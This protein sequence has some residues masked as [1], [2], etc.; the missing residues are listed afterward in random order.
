MPRVLFRVA[1]KVNES[2]WGFLIRVAENNGLD[3]PREILQTL[4]GSEDASA[5]WEDVAA[6]AEYCRCLPDEICQLGGIPRVVDP[7]RF[8]WRFAS[9][10]ISHERFIRAVTRP[11][12][13][14]CLQESPHLR[15]TWEI[16]LYTA[17]SK[18]GAALIDKCDACGKSLKKRRSRLAECSCGRD[19]RGLCAVKPEPSEMLVSAMIDEKFGGGDP[20]YVPNEYAPTVDKL[21]S[22]SLDGL[23]DTVWLLGCVVPALARSGVVNG[24]L[25]PDLQ[26]ATE[27]S[28]CAM[29]TL[30]DWPRRF[31]DQLE[32]IG[33]RPNPPGYSSSAWRWFAPL[34]RFFDESGD[35]EDVQFVRMAFEY[36]LREHGRANGRISMQRVRNH[37]REFDFA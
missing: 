8:E 37:Q 21:S 11:V 30:S 10:V 5:S 3:G 28:C 36:A 25:K 23:L 32:V 4:L 2:L 13:P 35:R 1:P 6:I 29:Q 18:H 19:L 12:C 24:R 14:Q 26:R 16:S 34:L 33:S 15:A 17:C 9:H 27:I 20:G 7:G 31:L 22:L